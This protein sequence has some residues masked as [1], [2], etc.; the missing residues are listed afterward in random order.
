MDTVARW[1][2]D[3]RTGDSVAAE[4]LWETYFSRMVMIARSKLKDAP[5]AG[6]DEEDVALS[7][8]K[9]FCLAA[10]EG[11]VP[12]LL[13]RDSLWP[14]LVA[15]TANKSVDLIRQQN[16]LKRGGDHAN[17]GI[18]VS[19]I[20]SDAPSPEFVAE[21]AEQLNALLQRLDETGDADL[22]KI[23]LAKMEGATTSEI[24]VTLGCAR[25][26]IER[27]LQVIARVWERTP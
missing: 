10:R 16:R 13:D 18:S 27:K 26:T 5:R 14:L 6:A 8:F 15:I 22:H 7:A 9:S 1:I 25:R 11:K 19:E 12:R 2:E 20:L 21:M 24:A 3:L 23:A 4:R 17:A